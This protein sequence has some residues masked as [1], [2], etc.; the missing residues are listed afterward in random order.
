MMSPSCPTL[1]LAL[2]LASSAPS[3]S[4][5]QDAPSQFGTKEILQ[6]ADVSNPLAPGRGGEGDGGQEPTNARC[7]CTCPDSTVVTQPEAPDRGTH[8]DFRSIYVNATVTPD[9][10]KCSKVGG[11][12]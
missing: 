10:C 6:T 2:L 8:H 12:L 9:D 1:L 7:V 11:T 5:A 3:S 4:L